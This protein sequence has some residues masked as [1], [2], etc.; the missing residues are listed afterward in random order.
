M[1]TDLDILLRKTVSLQKECTR[2]NTEL[3]LLK[4]QV[5]DKPVTE[6]TV[7]EQRVETQ[8]N[9]VDLILT[10]LVTKIEIFIRLN[11]TNATTLARLMLS[12]LKLK[13]EQEVKENKMLPNVKLFDLSKPLEPADVYEKIKC[14][15]SSK[16]IVKTI[17]CVHDLERDAVISKYIWE[18]GS[19]EKTTL[20]ND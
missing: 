20:S 12:S 19:F 8:S 17:L 14:K 15:Q 1:Q 11:E 3:G 6:K 5:E 16:F 10:D 2:L 7:P 13:R 18:D 4:I 9:S